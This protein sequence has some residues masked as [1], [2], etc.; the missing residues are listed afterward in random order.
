[1]I[2]FQKYFFPLLILIVWLI[3]LFFDPGTR[4]KII[5][6]GI[7]GK[8]VLTLILIIGVLI[9]FVINDMRKSGK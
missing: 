6:T 3:I 9:L 2:K 7:V 8:I 1:M 5:L 4:E